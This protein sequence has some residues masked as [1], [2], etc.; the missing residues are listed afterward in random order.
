[1]DLRLGTMRMTASHL[2]N[3]RRGRRTSCYVCRLR[4]GR[5][6]CANRRI[7]SVG[8]DAVPRKPFWSDPCATDEPEDKEMSDALDVP[9]AMAI[10]VRLGRRKQSALGQQQQR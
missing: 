3:I 5:G 4:C 8:T 1:M 10:G 2:T 7:F 9:M 6:K